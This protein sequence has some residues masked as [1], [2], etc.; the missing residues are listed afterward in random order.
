MNRIPFPVA[1][2]LLLALALASCS[3]TTRVE[4]IEPV[5]AGSGTL[6]L[7]ITGL[8]N[9]S[10]QIHASLFDSPEGFPRDTTLVL[11]SGT[12]ELISRDTVA[13]RFENV[14]YGYYAIALLHDENSNGA[15]DTGLLGIPSEGFGFSNNPRIGFGSPSFE[16][17][18]F[19]LDQPEVTLQL[20]MHYF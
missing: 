2:S 1:A 15:L 13:V 14:S 4:P 12:V 20:Q 11:R 19:R 8:K 3:T 7:E 18:R 5:P 6:I 17:C 16:V 9:A 10:G